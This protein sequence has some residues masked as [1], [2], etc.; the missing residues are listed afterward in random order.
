MYSAGDQLALQTYLD[1]DHERRTRITGIMA[2]TKPHG[3]S[4][5]DQRFFQN[6]PLLTAIPSRVRLANSPRG[7]E[8][9]ETVLSLT[10]SARVHWLFGVAVMGFT[11]RTGIASGNLS[12]ILLPSSLSDILH[13][14]ALILSYYPLSLCLYPFIISLVSHRPYR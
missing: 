13:P 1:D 3:R 2:K 11:S 4:S 6:C 10:L 8:S 14:F 5:R 12:F 7:M 9:M